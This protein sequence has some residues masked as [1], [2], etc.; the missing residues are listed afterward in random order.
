VGTRL[1]S[2]GA[3]VALL[4]NAAPALAGNGGFAPVPPESPNAQDITD[5]WWFVSVF[6]LL[7]FVLVEGLLIA[8]VLF[9]R[10]R[11]RDRYAEGAQIHGSTKLETMW[12]IGPVVILFAIASFVF[13]KLPGIRDVPSAGAS[14]QALQVRVEGRQF[15]WQ[16]VYPNGVIAVRQLRAPVGVPVELT[17]VAPA[18]DVIHSWWIPALGGKIDAIPGI[19]NSTWFEA[20]QAGVFRGQCAELCGLE[21]ARMLAE[22]VA[23]PV[24]EFD[25][26]LADE[27]SAQAAGTS[28]LGRDTYADACATC[29]GLDGS[30]GAAAGAPRLAGSSLLEDPE[31]V[32]EI[33]RTGRGLMPA[34]GA[35]WS[36]RHMKALTDYLQEEL[37][38]GGQS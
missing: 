30:G 10:R 27:A 35:D 38:G 21:H 24:G 9:F 6:I 3:L 11:R 29:H 12:T 20:R 22:V 37:A 8:F 5:T 36:D 15:Y 14:G 13:V 25:A 26:W 19:V 32:E 33:V 1:V 2:A 31:A 18:T 23:M 34:V 17:V 7:V 4:A 16:Y 28:D